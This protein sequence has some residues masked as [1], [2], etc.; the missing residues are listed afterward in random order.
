VPG[1]PYYDIHISYISISHDI[2][3]WLL[4]WDIS[5]DSHFQRISTL[6]T[7]Q[8]IPVIFEGDGILHSQNG[9]PIIYTYDG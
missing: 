1:L 6:P 8:L 5:S 3:I 9:S 7:K 4:D 2:V